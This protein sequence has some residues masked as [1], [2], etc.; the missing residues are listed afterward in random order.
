MICEAALA[1]ASEL[2]NIALGALNQPIRAIFIIFANKAL[3]AD[4]TG[5]KTLSEQHQ[6]IIL[7]KLN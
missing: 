3:E 2:R 7:N 5:K 6:T 4:K 1:Q